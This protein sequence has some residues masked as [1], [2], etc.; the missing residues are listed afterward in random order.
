MKISWILSG[1][2][3]NFSVTSMRAGCINEICGF[4]VKTDAD[5]GLHPYATSAVYLVP[6]L[7]DEVVRACFDSFSALEEVLLEFVLL[8]EALLEMVLLV[9]VLL[10]EV[11][12]AGSLLSVLRATTCD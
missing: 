5:S 7:S 2:M 1:D 8:E 4:N 12:T 3:E 10:G 6:D 9:M 11:L